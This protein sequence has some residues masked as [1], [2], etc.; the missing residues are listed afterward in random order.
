[1]YYGLRAAPGSD[2]MNLPIRR[3][4]I[5]LVASGYGVAW[6]GSLAVALQDHSGDVAGP[7]G[8]GAFET[9]GMVL[10]GIT[11]PLGMLAAPLLGNGSSGRGGIVLFWC[12]AGLL[13]AIQW[14][15]IA[16]AGAAIWGQFRPQRATTLDLK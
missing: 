6:A 16:A 1:M 2:R 12:V 8:H 13:G 9:A 15:G 14:A 5:L 10:V 7:Q 11:Q 4:A 3:A